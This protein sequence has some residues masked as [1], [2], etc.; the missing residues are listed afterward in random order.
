MNN[1]YSRKKVA[2]S[3]LNKVWIHKEDTQTYVDIKELDY[4][5]GLGYSL[6]MLKRKGTTKKDYDC[7]CKVCSKDY[8]GGKYS[9]M[10]KECYSKMKGEQLALTRGGYNNEK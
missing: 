7:H 9:T 3:K 5:L 8:K 4:Y 1:S 2:E 6:G 10:C